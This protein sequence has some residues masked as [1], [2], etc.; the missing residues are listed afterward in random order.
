V[1]LMQAQV[2][3]RLRIHGRTV[4]T[5][6]QEAEILEVRGEGGQPPYLVRFHDGRE[7]LMFPGP[8]CQVERGSATGQRS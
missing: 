7:T 6:D 1:T 2:G 5:R 4:G 8:D 3:E